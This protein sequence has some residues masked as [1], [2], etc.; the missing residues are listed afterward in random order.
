MR[1]STSTARRTCAWP[2]WTSHLED[3]RRLG[4]LSRR[5]DLRD[6]RGH[7]GRGRRRV[8]ADGRTLLD[9]AEVERLARSP[10]LPTAAVNPGARPSCVN[11]ASL[12]GFE[13]VERGQGAA[14][15][16]ALRISRSWSATRLLHEKLMPVLGL[17]RSPSV[18]HA[19]AVC[20]LVTEHGGLGHTSAVY[21][22]DEDVVAALRADGAHRPHTR[23]RAHRRGGARRRLQ[24]DDARRSRWAAA[25]GAAR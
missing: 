16:A 5:A 3:L 22:V 1:P 15:P 4:D 14:G 2:S 8:P 20:E 10:S 23:K 21:A 9:P 17:V 6:R 7:L 13:A 18:E 19:L 24:L 12:A 11:L 25:P